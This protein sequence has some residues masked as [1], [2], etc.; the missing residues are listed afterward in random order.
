M[1]TQIL[2]LEKSDLAKTAKIEYMDMDSSSLEII[3]SFEILIY[4][5]L[6]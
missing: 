1:S 4:R 3:H 6:A 2:T 5:P